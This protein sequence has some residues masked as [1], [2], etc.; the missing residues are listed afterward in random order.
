MLRHPVMLSLSVIPFLFGLIGF[1]AAVSMLMSSGSA[2]IDSR[3]TSMMMMWF[4]GWSDQWYWMVFYWIVKALMFA[5]VLMLGAVIAIATTMALA[6]PVNE[7]ISVRVERD[8]LEGASGEVSWRDMP[9]VLF[10]ELAKALVVILIP[11]LLLLIPGINIF[12]GVVAAFLLGWDF[13]DYPLARR[14]WGFGRR[15]AFVTGE[16]W[17]VLGFGLWLAI[18]VLHLFLLPLAVAGGTILNIEA[19]AR[20]GLV[21][22]K[23]VQLVAKSGSE[24]VS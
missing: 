17:T 19:M 4:S 22:L 5:S 8:L 23:D 13:Y 24:S 1:V 21:T 6:S 12:A 18:P 3:L 9:R 10:G 16:F 15:V 20:K 14:G 2:W 7:Y 11:T